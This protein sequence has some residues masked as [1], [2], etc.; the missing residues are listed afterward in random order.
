MFALCVHKSKNRM[1]VVSTHPTHFHPRI[2]KKGFILKRPFKAIGLAMALLFIQSSLRAQAPGNDLCANAT[3]LTVGGD[4]SPTAGTLYNATNTNPTGSTCGNRADVWYRFVVPANST[5]VTITVSL[6][7]NPS[8][9]ATNNT[10]IEVFNTNNCTVNGTS[11]GGCNN[12]TSARLYTGLT[13]GATY[14]FRV[15][16]SL[17]PNTNPTR[18][19][20]NV[21]VTSNENP[22]IART[23]I[24]GETLDGHVFGATA[25]P[26]VP[27]DCATGNPDDDVWYRFTAIGSYATITLS[28]LG[29]SLTTSGAMLQLFSG[30]PGALTSIACG[31]GIINKTSGLT[32]GNTYYVRVY[33]S[34]TGQA[35]FS[36]ANAAF[37][38]SVT[39]SAPVVA[40]SGRMKE[41]YHQTI[42]SSVNT[43][44]NP[45]EVTYG[46]DDKLWITESKGYRLYRM[47]PV[48]GA[49]DTV[50]DVS[51]NSTFL[52]LADRT[53]NMTFNIGANNPQ[54]GFAGMALHPKFL[55]PTTPQ[56]FVYIAYVY[57]YTG[58]ADPNGIYYT[59]RLVRFTYNTGTGKLESPVSLCDTIPGGNDHNSQRVIIVPVGGTP[60]LF[61]AAGDV[62]A[63]QFANRLRP[64]KSQLVNSY[65]GKILRFNLVPDAD[66]GTLDRWIP[67]DNPYNATL[68]VQSAVWS[69]GIRNNQGFAYDTALNILYGSSHGPYSDDEI[70]IIEPGKNYGHPI[71][72]GY[73]ADNNYNGSTAGSPLP[74]AGG[75]S[76]CPQITN[77]SGTALSLPNYK[78]PLFSAY[79]APT[80]TINNIW[81]T[82]PGNGG[83]P[84]EGWSGLDLYD[85]ALVPGWKKSLIA[86]SL[87]WGRLVRIRLAPSGDSVIQSGLKD[88]V[89]YFG[90]INRYRDLTIAPGGKDIYVIMDKSTTTSGP[91]AANP[92]V[93]G[94]PGCVQK[95]TFLGYSNI[96][97]KSSIDTTID[98]TSTTANTCV[99]GTTIT[100]NSANSNFWVPITGPDGNIL[101]EI[102][103]NGQTLG[104]VTSSVY[105]HTGAIRNKGNAR[106]LDRNITITPQ[107]QPVTP[108]KVR[109]YIS[110]TEFDALDAHVMSQIASLSD[111]KV[112][113]NN[114]ACL[115]AISA[116][117][118]IIDPTFSERHGPNGYM[119]QVDISSF[120]SFYFGAANLTLPLNLVTFTGNYKSGNS[121]LKWETSNEK[122]SSHFEIERSVGNNPFEKLATVDAKGGLNKKETYNYVDNNVI[123]LG[124][125][126]VSYRLK[127]VDNNGE[128]TYSNV[129]VV[130]I[131][132][133]LVTSVNLFPNPAAKTTVLSITSPRDQKITLQLVDNAGRVVMTENETV[134][135]GNS[136]ITLR[137]DHLPAG[138][139][140]LQIKGNYV[141]TIQKLQKQ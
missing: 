112:H 120:S 58:G 41:M 51:Q 38:L 106:Y 44:D 135:K 109:L 111:L 68:G 40:S 124:V 10:Y 3:V 24:P 100:I 56:N 133:I 131:P 37:K 18:W 87:K 55:D 62:G 80:A 69:I 113:K 121:Y 46:P 34:G 50:L 96:G 30:T 66:A 85:Y 11:T 71:V 118:T 9:L 110:K 92:V 15:N 127:I 26:S 19:N 60:Y 28:N 90:S 74:T 57:S 140:F 5:S 1:K 125:P 8:S 123:D 139:Y 73:A 72:I 98:V 103:A 39:P 134:R 115:P 104:Q 117:S 137:V 86:T 48:T 2:F 27:V 16:T 6:T 75:V 76:T 53:F 84:S 105:R 102:F 64:M 95:Y 67:N 91:S 43:L 23:I 25:S 12:I 59:N 114:D 13:A 33:S 63:G 78:D 88:T 97:G 79:A 126:F 94:C 77:E 119:L 129:V 82:N 108:V 128:Y 116:A 99:P 136:R 31:R 4:C 83:W 32:S 138:S 70:N 36:Q 141:N 89:S 45:W 49:R 130:S 81:N 42:I 122:N 14:F 132:D 101:A 22:G 52:P 65:E 7:S 17:T 20:F 107:F 47:D 54:G 61:Y 93:P 21:C 29:S 35:G